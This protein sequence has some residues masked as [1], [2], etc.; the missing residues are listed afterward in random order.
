MTILPEHWTE[1]YYRLVFTHPM[2]MG[3]VRNS[4]GLS[5]ASTVLVLLLGGSVAWLLAR[6]RFVGSALLDTLCMMP[7]A[8][9]GVI[10]AFGYV[11]GY[12]GTFLDPRVNPIALLIAAYAIRRL[13][14]AVRAVFAGFQQVGM[15][16]EEASASLGSSPGATLRRVSLP[17]ISASL[18][19]AAV[20]SFAF[21]M[22]EVSDSLILAMEERFYPITKA[23]YMLLGRLSDGVYLASAMGVLGMVLLGVALFV[24]QRLLGHRM[25]D[26][27]RA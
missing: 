17:L 5:V 20:L 6:R 22:L 2:S 18:V 11:G 7:L 14:I 23:I 1:Q 9:P 12:S 19:G 25:G 16:L 13:P 15:T 24:G 21:A 4:I 3:A 8:V 26:M 27:F 10:L